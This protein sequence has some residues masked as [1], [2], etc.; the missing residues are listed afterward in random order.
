[1]TSRTSNYDEWKRVSYQHAAVQVTDM[2]GE[3]YPKY[4]AIALRTNF[5][6]FVL[7][8]VHPDGMRTKLF[9]AMRDVDPLERKVGKKNSDLT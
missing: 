3:Q 6:Y 7:S 1:M 9:Q 4:W 5:Y 2:P 8:A